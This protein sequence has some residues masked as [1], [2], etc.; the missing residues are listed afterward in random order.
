MGWSKFLMVF[1][2]SEHTCM[3][4]KIL[5]VVATSG[6]VASVTNELLHRI[7]IFIIVK[8]LIIRHISKDTGML[9]QL[10][11]RIAGNIGGN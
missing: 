4:M 1:H 8:G 10:A 6:Y 5:C 3:A 11:Y 7:C 9:I 2:R